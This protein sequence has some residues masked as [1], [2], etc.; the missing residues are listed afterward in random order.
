[1]S[2]L[3]KIILLISMHLILQIIAFL[4][5]SQGLLWSEF[6]SSLTHLG[7]PFVCVILITSCRIWCITKRVSQVWQDLPWGKVYK[8]ASWEKFENASLGTQSFNVFFFWPLII[9]HV[10]SSLIRS[11]T[12]ESS[13]F[14][15]S[16]LYNWIRRYGSCNMRF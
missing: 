10:V 13:L 6:T 4:R 1:M 14:H 15:F 16:P 12:D 5:S 7:T 2:F 3:K 8:F 9:S 11:I